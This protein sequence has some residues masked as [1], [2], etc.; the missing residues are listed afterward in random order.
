VL[1]LL[2]KES[3]L[4]VITQEIIL[5]CV[6][7]SNSD[8][9]L[10]VFQADRNKLDFLFH[11]PNNFIEERE[12][13]E[14]TA[15]SDFSFISK[16]LEL[17]NRPLIALNKQNNIGFNLAQALNSESLPSLEISQLEQ[18]ATLL[19]FTIS[20]IKTRE[21]NTALENRLLQSQKLETIGKL[22]S[23]MAHD[24]SN[25]LSS[26]FGSLNLLRKRV[27]QNEAV[28][29]LI[30]NIENCSVRAKDLTKKICTTYLVTARKFTRCC[31]TYAL[32]PKKLLVKR[33]Q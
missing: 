29:R 22:S 11:D 24:F 21:L 30:D 31:L 5:R 25:L 16:W 1:I 33:E 4:D 3:S 8:F 18:F 19:S 6:N 13:V 26:I 10:I 28:D 23:G 17:N 20:N 15:N 27:P 2:D 7:T 9:G 12:E 32:M 14:K